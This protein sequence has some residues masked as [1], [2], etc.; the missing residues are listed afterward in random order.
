MSK[1][2]SLSAVAWVPFGIDPPHDQS[3]AAA[4]AWVEAECRSEGSHGLLVTPGMGPLVCE[5]L[6]P[7]AKRHARTSSRSRGERRGGGSGPV[8]IHA[9]GRLVN[10][11]VV[12]S[13]VTRKPD[14][15]ETSLQGVGSFVAIEV[16][17]DPYPIEPEA[18]AMTQIP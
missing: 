7:F 2:R 11:P 4:A 16:A 15:I 6:G 14:L 17:S 3:I 12:I 1:T 9:F 18:S 5:P 13:K 10:G 8:M